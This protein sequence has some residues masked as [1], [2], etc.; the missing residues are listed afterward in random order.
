MHSDLVE[1]VQQLEAEPGSEISLDHRRGGHKLTVTLRRRDDGGCD[2]RVEGWRG[3]HRESAS[4]TRCKVAHVDK[5]AQ[6]LV[7]QIRWQLAKSGA[8]YLVGT[9]AATAGIGFAYARHLKVQQRKEFE[10]KFSSGLI[11][12]LMN[13]TCQVSITP[14]KSNKTNMVISGCNTGDGRHTFDMSMYDVWQRA[15][16]KI[17][18]QNPYVK[19]QLDKL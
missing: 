16:Q 5:V 9:V 1:L 17:K 11:V 14:D 7:R 10:S 3:M 18:K 6:A 13:T 15:E 4:A 8:K 12:R 2:V 19:L